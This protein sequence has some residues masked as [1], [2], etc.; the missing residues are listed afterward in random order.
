[1]DKTEFLTI[2][3]TFQNLEVAKQTL[4]SVIAETKKNNARLIVHDS[5]E[6]GREEKWRYLQELNKHNDFFLLLST[7]LSMAH[8]RNMCLKLGQELYAPEYIC[9][10]EDDHGFNEG[11]IPS[12]INAM[13]KYYGNK[14]PNGL[15]YG[16]FTACGKHH[17]AKKHAIDEACFYPDS[18]SSPGILGGA[19]SCFR[20]APTSHWINVL[21]G[22]DTDEY[23]ISTFQTKNLNFRNYHKG[24]TTCILGENLSFDVESIGRGTSAKTKLSLWDETYTASD[25]R[26]NYHGKNRLDRPTPN[27][28]VLSIA[29][30]STKNINT[31]LTKK[32]ASNIFSR[33]KLKLSH[34]IQK[35]SSRTL[36]HF[37]DVGFHGDEHLLHLVEYLAG[38]CK[39]FVETGANVGSTLVYVAQ[40]YPSMSCLSCEPDQSAFEQASAN[41]GKYGNVTLFN[42][43]S[44][45]FIEHLSKHEPGLFSEQCFFWLDAH[46]YGFEWPLKNELE[47]ITGHFSAAYI[48][49]DDFKVPGR[50]HFGYDQYQEQICSYD[51][52]KDALDPEKTYQLYYPTYEDKT[53]KHH[54]LRGW[55][56]LVFGHDDFRI[57]EELSCKMERVL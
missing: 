40:S 37:L 28:Q 19:N 50:D 3:P 43:M 25:F 27:E 35:E 57:P 56:L 55:G 29:K 53:S 44:Q 7:N 32:D 54:P 4:P 6:K 22:Y 49:I 23:L 46:G 52:V 10:I 9:M 36:S 18:E 16:L 2:F 51:Y 11:V 14:S 17:Y 39:V 24:F 41:A 20:C 38:N 1:M 12:L 33:L 8:V 5:S 26:S 30:G 48:L 13:K 34:I 31:P 15:R 42:G 21:K 45:Q 47:F